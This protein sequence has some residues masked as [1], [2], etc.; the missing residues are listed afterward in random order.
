MYA[1]GPSVSDTDARTEADAKPGEEAFMDIPMAVVVDATNVEYIKS[2]REEKRFFHSNRRYLFVG[3]VAG[4]LVGGIAVAVVVAHISKKTSSAQSLLA[5]TPTSSPIISESSERRRPTPSPVSTEPTQ[6]PTASPISSPT[7]SLTSSTTSSSYERYAE[8]CVHGEN[9]E[10][11][12]NKSVLECAA[13]CD[14]IPNCMG[15]EYGV[16]YGGEGN[17]VPGDCQPQSSNDITGCDGKYYNLD[18]YELARTLG[19]YW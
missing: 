4:C 6:S 19:I 14:N 11:H 18:F 13:I 1:A 2:E 3:V 17:Y 10:K 16:D 8:S 15:F 5:P 9:I 12:S 7:S